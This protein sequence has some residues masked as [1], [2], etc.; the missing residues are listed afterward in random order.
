MFLSQKPGC[1]L[2]YM[3]EKN[4]GSWFN[5]IFSSF[6]ISNGLLPLLEVILHLLWYCLLLGVKLD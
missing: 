4:L 3:F 6:M 5:D 1:I 2:L